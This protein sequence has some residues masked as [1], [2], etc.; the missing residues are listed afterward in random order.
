M[1]KSKATESAKSADVKASAGVAC[2]TPVISAKDIIGLCRP[3]CASAPVPVFIL[4]ST[5]RII[6]AS[7]EASA[8]TGKPL[9]DIVGSYFSD[10]LLYDE[11]GESCTRSFFSEALGKDRKSSCIAILKNELGIKLTVEI[12]MNPFANGEDRFL[13]VILRDLSAERNAKLERDEY[14]V[15]YDSLFQNLNRA[16]AIYEAIDNGRDFVFKDF[17]QTAEAME[18]LKKVDVVGKPVTQ[19][20]PGVET[21]GLLDVFKRVWKTGK[22]EHL[23]PSVYEDPRLG[24]TW[25]KNDVYKLPTG[26]LVCVYVDVTDRME[27]MRKLEESEIRYRALFENM[28]SGVAVYEA[29]DGGRDFIIKEFNE[30][31]ERSDKVKRMEVIGKPI[32]EVF[33]GAERI[34][35]LN[36]L[37]RV[38][39]EAKPEY[40]PPTLYEDERVGNVWWEDYVYKL[41]TGELVATFENVTE[42]MKAGEDLRK[43]VAQV[44]AERDKIDTIV[45]SIADAV[46]VVDKE[47]KIILFNEAASSLGGVKVADAIGKPYDA[48]LRFVAGADERRADGYIHSARENGVTTPAADDVVLVNQEGKRI[49]VSSSASPLKSSEGK[50]TGAVVVFRDVSSEREADMVKTEYAS[51]TSR[52]MQSPL[53]D[54]QW[55]LELIL[56]GKAGEIP[57]KAKGYLEQINAMNERMI[58]IVE[59][60]LTISKSETTCA[61]M[62]TESVDIVQIIKEVITENIDLIRQNRIT[63]EIGESL[64]K[65][66]YLRVEESLIREVFRHLVSNAVKYSKGSGTVDIVFDG[67]RKDALL[68]SVRDNGYGIPSRQQ[69][70][71]FEK[72][73]RADNVITKFP[74]GTGLGLSACKSAVESLGGKIWFTS[75]ENVGTTFYFTLP[76]TVVPGTRSRSATP[77]S[78]AYSKSARE[79]G[80]LDAD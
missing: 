3:M 70:R 78:E 34:G 16:V 32:T 55:Y 64:P 47:D 48:V 71:V 38:W 73:F 20:F 31:A 25:R 80:W 65:K 50:T 2:E 51:I 8:F 1:A 23:P 39:K 41:P 21:L 77:R 5:A 13:I 61:I 6:S 66:F 36:V 56:R 44:I 54:A 40:F 9:S 53:K 17:N 24:R 29:I 18:R 69:S 43:S 26:E 28:R 7:E 59:K 45:Q 19:V 52:Q 46:F 57:E 30:A 63:V 37:R 72:F 27:T 67:S 42:R 35:F 33:P 58:R 68:F 15:R 74:E 11:S 62:P 79:E 75:I 60:L 22:Q 49:P 4:D 12:L 76:K 14:E 10:L